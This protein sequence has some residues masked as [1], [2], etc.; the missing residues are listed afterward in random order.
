M[1]RDLP[2]NKHSLQCTHLAHLP[3]DGDG[4]KAKVAEDESQPARGVARAR[5]HHGSRTGQ[6]VEDKHKVAVLKGEGGK[7]GTYR[8]NQEIGMSGFRV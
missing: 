8:I 1:I 5:E 7:G 2:G 6:L 4:C 3:G